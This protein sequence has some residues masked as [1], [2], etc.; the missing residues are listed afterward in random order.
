MQTYTRCLDQRFQAD[1]EG[2]TRPINA[3]MYI[4]MCV[5]VCACVRVCVCVRKYT[6]THIHACMHTYI[7][8]SLR[9]VKQS[10]VARAHA[11]E[12]TLIQKHAV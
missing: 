6:N 5:W 10:E 8:T 3:Y 9:D 1:D 2:C 12:R 11:H 7:H 4:Y